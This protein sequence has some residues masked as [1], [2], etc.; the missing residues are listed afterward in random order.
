M[1]VDIQNI[2]IECEDCGCQLESEVSGIGADNDYGIKISIKHNGCACV[3]EEPE[4]E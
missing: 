3:P 1:K 4:G 2:I